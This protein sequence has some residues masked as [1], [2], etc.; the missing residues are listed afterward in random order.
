MSLVSR[1]TV[2]KRFINIMHIT[3]C[4]RLFKC[5][6]YKMDM[7]ELNIIMWLPGVVYSSMKCVRHFNWI[8]YFEWKI[9]WKI[10]MWPSDTFYYLDVFVCN[11]FYPGPGNMVQRNPGFD[12]NYLGSIENLCWVK[13][14]NGFSMQRYFCVCKVIF[15]VNFLLRK[16]HSCQSVF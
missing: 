3:Y 6:F 10:F 7:W 16:S 4:T 15:K 8:T 12:L 5:I 1:K 11:N 14:K 13:S 9:W 2:L